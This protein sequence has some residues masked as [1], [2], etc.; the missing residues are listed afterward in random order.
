MIGAPFYGTAR[1]NF[2][3]TVSRVNS[4]GEN[5]K[6]FAVIDPVVAWKSMLRVLFK[7]GFSIA[8]T[9]AI[10]LIRLQASHA[11]AKVSRMRKSILRR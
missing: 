5:I 6:I 4:L 8:T 11:H 10:E 7:Q 2:V 3:P 1:Q 9:R